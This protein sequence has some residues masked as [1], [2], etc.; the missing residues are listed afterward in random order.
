MTE[1][2]YQNFLDSKAITSKPSGIDADGVI[3]SGLFDWQRKIV[4][5][6]LS[7]GRAAIF[8]DCGLGKT[9]MQLAWASEVPGKV[10]IFTPLAVAQQTV[11]EAARFGIDA[12][13]SS[14][15]ASESK[16]TI[17]NYHKMH[18]FDAG[19]FGGIVLDESSILKSH[20]GKT[21]NA[22]I[23]FAQHIPFR[24]ACT[25]TPAPNDHMEIGNH[26]EFVGSM[27]R[28]EMLST[29]FVHD[30]GNTSKWRL[31]KH[32]VDDFWRW[33][34]SW[35]VA[36]KTPADIGYDDSGYVLPELS[37]N[38]RM[39]DSDYKQ[40]GVL[41]PS[42]LSL[43]DLRDARRCSIKNRVQSIADLV[44]GTD[45]QWIVWCDLNDEADE[46]ERKIDDGLQVSGADSDRDKV[47][48]MNGFTDGSIR[49]L[50]T[51]PSI[52]GFGMNWQNCNQ[53]AF[54][55]LSH[56]YER[57]YQAIRRCW[58]F[59]QKN[60][61]G[62]HIA[63]SDPELS[64][65]DSIKRKSEDA[66][67]MSKKM[68]GSMSSMSDWGA[69]NVSSD[70]YNTATEHGD[71]WVLNRSDCVDGVAKMKS[72]SIH[73][74]IFSPPFASLYT[75]SNSVRD[76]GNCKDHKS[77][78]SQ[79]EYLV[80]ELIRVTMPGRLLSFHCMNLP[81]SK[82]R[83]GVIGLTDFRGEMIRL[84]QDKGWIYHSEVCIWKDPVV[85]M[86]RTKALGLLHKQLKKDS[87]MSRQGIADY[88]VTMRKPGANIEPV[89]H[90]NE[91]FPVH[92]WQRYAS[93]IW[94]DINPSDT[95]QYRSARASSD[96]KHIC[97]LQLQVIRRAM[98][99]WSNPGDIVLSPFAGIG[100][101]GH[102]ALSMGRQFV[103]FELKQSY[104]DQACLNLAAAARGSDQLDLAV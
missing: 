36:I 81:T 44:N 15:G 22:L 48:K 84:F 77:F 93:P 59:G 19:E 4:K 21:R 51:K 27:T 80:D 70:D 46:L 97:P 49:V 3:N 9:F 94:S 55:G 33:V 12:A 1:I 72:D 26:A 47:S 28:T 18:K 2:S 13:F 23:E 79:F 50:I 103:G 74:T 99:L 104:Y 95:L 58:R 67:N 35:A 82:S 11:K 5:W 38:V 43:T 75:Y 24:L 73:Y 56:S 89:T 85:A 78:F 41:F 37:T 29:F 40:D 101:E 96:E 20:D 39:V 52:A 61:V 88:L 57:Y 10:L 92:V 69:L 30:G 102:V 64:V 25:A 45:G 83:D 32:A 6:S 31:K 91:S 60:A 17:T 100:S 76:M 98:K 68:I 86:Q 8:A 7:K 16:I 34:G 42:A 54:V 66:E 62:V 63:M 53:V 90:N 14:G 71:G 87:C 65:L